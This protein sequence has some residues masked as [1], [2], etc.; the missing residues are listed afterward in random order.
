MSKR[1]TETEKWDH[2]WFRKLSP[3]MKCIWLYICDRCDSAGVWNV[4]LE[5]MSF[6]IGESINI[7]DFSF[8]QEKFEWLCPD[9]II[10]TSFIKFQYGELSAEC[11]PHKA[12]LT[13]LKMLNLS[14]ANLNNLKGYPKGIETLQDKT[15]QEQEQEKEEGVQ[16]EIHNA[17]SQETESDKVEPPIQIQNSV[18]RFDQRFKRNAEITEIKKWLED[19]KL[20]T[21]VSQHSQKILET[22]GSLDIFREWII[23]RNKT[24]Q[25]RENGPTLITY[26]VDSILVEI[27]VIRPRSKFK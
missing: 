10:L 5:A 23:Q 9:K 15:I 6:H 24:F 16:G 21:R 22:F 1:F 13:K 11:K 19:Q 14:K 20:G 27:K 3:K 8:F 18:Q 2:A 4:D 17:E 26:L 12:I 25:L 7:D